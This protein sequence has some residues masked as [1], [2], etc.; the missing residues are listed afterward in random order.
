MHFSHTT[1]VILLQ[2]LC[3][4]CFEKPCARLSC[5]SDGYLLLSDNIWLV[6]SAAFGSWLLG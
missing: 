3:G 4:T 2:V 5:S 1:G 6:H